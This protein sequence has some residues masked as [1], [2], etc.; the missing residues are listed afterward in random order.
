MHLVLRCFQRDASQHTGRFDTL[1]STRRAVSG[2][3]T[4]F[5]NVVQRVLT[6]G[7]RLGWV[8]VLVVYVQSVLT[9]GLSAFFAQQ[10][11]VNER[12]SGFARKLHHHS[13][14]R[15]SVH[16][17]VFARN[18][19][20][21][22]VDNLQKHVVR[23]GL[24]G[25]A[26]LVSIGN[27]SPSH[28]FAATLHQFH[29][30]LVLDVFHRHL[31]FSHKSDAVCYLLNQ[32]FVFAFVGVEHRFAHGSHYFLLVKAHNASVSLYNCLYHSRE[33]VLLGSLFCYCILLQSYFKYQ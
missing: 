5:Q 4:T 7:K 25:H 21:F 10:I 12:L 29:L 23:L 18:V 33:G 13:G 30:H 20:I 27:V 17:G 16:V 28:I 14:W 19:V 9:N 1:G 15:I 8:I 2:R 22:H 26:A 24:S 11:V 3:E 31:R 32:S 6:A